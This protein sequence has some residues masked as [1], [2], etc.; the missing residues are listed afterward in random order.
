MG[1]KT[2][3]QKRALQISQNNVLQIEAEYKHELDTNPEY[4]LIVD[5]TNKYALSTTTKE[6]VRY[7]IEYRNI[8]TAATF[9]NIENDEAL[10]IFS[11]FAVQQEIRRISKA[12]YHRQFSKKMLSMD[13]I[14]GFLSSLIEDSEVPIADRLSNKDK[15]SV[16]RLL[17]EIN[18]YKIEAMT[19]PSILMMKDITELVKDLSVGAIKSLIN[20]NNS[21]DNENNINS[22]IIKY[23]NSERIKKNEPT[24]LPEEAAYI[25][26][27]SADEA[28]KLLNEYYC[29]DENEEVKSNE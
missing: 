28:L 10:E 24:L 7:Y 11:S 6:F 23:A 2:S 4:S 5:P 13:E 1:K 27:L 22:E 16:I 17:I 20:Q 26:S 15:L 21:K 18:K 29:D 3:L 19:D 12:L 14:C 25:E 8:G 9:C